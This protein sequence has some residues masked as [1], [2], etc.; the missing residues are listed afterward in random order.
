MDLSVGNQM[1]IY[2]DDAFIQASVPHLG[3]MVTSQWCHMLSDTTREELIA[4]AV[5]IG[6]RKSWLQ[7]K[8][9]GV[10]FDVTEG[11]R[12]LAVVRGAIEISYRTDEWKRV[13]AIARGQ[14][15]LG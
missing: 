5:S 10:H 1:T 2:V 11:K 6:L 15:L 13:T 7:D 4:F 14:Y 8:P 3:R 12:R 9:S